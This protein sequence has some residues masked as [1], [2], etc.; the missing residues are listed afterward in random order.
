MTYCRLSDNTTKFDFSSH[1]IERNK[2][3]LPY[4]GTISADLAESIE[5]AI[6]GRLSQEEWDRMC[7]IYDDPACFL[8][9]TDQANNY[10]ILFNIQPDKI[11]T[12]FCVEASIPTVGMVSAH[13]PVLIDD[14][15]CVSILDSYFVT[16]DNLYPSSRRYFKESYMKWKTEAK[17]LS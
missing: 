5:S 9:G 17:K 6:A 16:A 4:S 1:S 3:R 11:R 10:S 2:I 12:S 7:D 13:I 15:L 8:F 14:S